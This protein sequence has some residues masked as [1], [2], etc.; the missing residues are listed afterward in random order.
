M[1]DGE[2]WNGRSIMLLVA[3]IAVM[4]A[5]VGLSLYLL[6]NLG[7]GLRWTA[8]LVIPAVATALL[9]VLVF[10]SGRIQKWIES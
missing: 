1:G 4:A 5:T 8:R 3:V 6:E 10:C 9:A 2:G 7:D